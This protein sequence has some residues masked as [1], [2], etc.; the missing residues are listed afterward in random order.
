MVNATIIIQLWVKSGGKPIL[1]S[2]GNDSPINLRQDFHFRRQRLCNV[3]STDKCHGHSITNANNMV[4]RMETAQLATVG[5]ALHANRHNVEITF[6]EQDHTGTGAKDGKT[7]FDGLLD[8]SE[9]TKLT[10]QA[11]LHRA[12]AAR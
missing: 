7:G 3:W 1:L 5:I 9:E 4:L 11:H 6:R 10:K 2:H 12:L 8:G